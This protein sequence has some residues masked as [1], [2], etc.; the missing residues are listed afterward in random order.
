MWPSNDFWSC[1]RIV[2][3]SL[4]VFGKFI[5]YIHVRL[6]KNLSSHVEEHFSIFKGKFSPTPCKFPTYYFSLAPSTLQNQ[7]NGSFSDG[8][9]VDICASTRSAPE[10]K[11]STIPLHHQ[12]NDTSTEEQTPKLFTCPVD[13]CVKCFQQYGSLRIHLQ[14]GSCKLVPEREN[15]FDKAKICYRDKLLHDRVIHPVLT[16]STL[17][18]PVGDIKPKGWA[19]KVTKKATR[20]N[21]KQKKYLEEKFFLGQETGHKVEAV[22]VAQEMRYAKDEAGSRRF[23]LDE[24]LTPQQ[25]QSFFSRM[26]AKIRN[27]QEEVVEEDTT[28]AEDQAAFSSTRAD[29][30]ENC[31]LTHPT[32]VPYTH[33]MAL[34]S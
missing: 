17:P 28:A 18:L 3:P 7:F 16:S 31:Q 1:R 23:T 8:D 15:L 14:Y 33:V 5:Y 29:I 6:K 12:I 32:W 19:L 10:L 25:V 9:F 24:F 13:G 30:L 34:K 20:F 26:A 27:R 21:E 11:T 4:L 2:K 22:T